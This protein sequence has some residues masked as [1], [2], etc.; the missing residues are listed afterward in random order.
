MEITPYE[1]IGREFQACWTLA[2]SYVQRLGEGNLAWFK[3]NLHPPF[4]EH[5]SFRL[6]NQL[7]FVRLEDTGG[8]LRVPGDMEGLLEIAEACNGHPLVMPMRYAGGIWLPAFPGWGLFD[9]RSRNPVNPMRLVGT[10]RVALS[11]WELHDLA[12]H[13]VMAKLPGARPHSFCNHPMISPSIWY[14]GPSGTEWAIVRFARDPGSHVPLPSNW[15]QLCESSE[16]RGFGDGY[17][18]VV[19]FQGKD[20]QSGDPI[21]NAPLYRCQDIH[22]SLK[23]LRRF[24][25]G[26][27]YPATEARGQG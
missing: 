24:A 23:P 9:P 5:F 27:E 12:V 8:R 22:I 19:L 21:P 26:W 2:A 20:P 3:G 16:G 15:A 11:D 10:E 25:I 14:E 1:G 6:G 4:F 17:F 18:A 7:F 13:S